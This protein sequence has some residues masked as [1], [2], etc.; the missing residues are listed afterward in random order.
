[1]R[2]LVHIAQCRRSEG[3]SKMKPIKIKIHALINRYIVSAKVVESSALLRFRF[4]HPLNLAFVQP[5]REITLL[6][7]EFSRITH[8]I[9]CIRMK[10]F[11][12]LQTDRSVRPSLC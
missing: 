2:F 1:M 6:E 12:V 8:V 3:W 10:E 7:Y 11:D 4:K 5:G 9:N